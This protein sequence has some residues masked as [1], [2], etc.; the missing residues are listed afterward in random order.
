MSSHLLLLMLL[1]ISFHRSGLGTGI[2]RK[3][4]WLQKRWHSS[5]SAQRGHLHI[6]FSYMS[7]AKL[8]KVLN[9]WMFCI[10]ILC[11]MHDSIMW[12]PNHI[13]GLSTW[14]SMKILKFWSKWRFVW[15]IQ[16]RFDV[17][18]IGC[19]GT[20][21]NEST[22]TK[23]DCKPNIFAME[24]WFH[25]AVLPNEQMCY[26]WCMPHGQTDVQPMRSLNNLPWEINCAEFIILSATVLA[27]S[28][29]HVMG[30]Y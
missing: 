14:M 13:L 22:A 24:P 15:V 7:T 1:H 12:F 21:A 8:I 28:D 29:N 26:L 19:D 20:F 6:I 18:A 25:H 4:A 3:G 17:L 5:G 30:M 27:I 11:H 16:H 9:E 23:F 2:G 10:V